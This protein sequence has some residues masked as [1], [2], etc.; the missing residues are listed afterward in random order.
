MEALGKELGVSAGEAAGLVTAV[1]PLFSI[2]ATTIVKDRSGPGVG[3]RHSPGTC[4][5]MSSG[6][7]GR[8][9]ELA[10]SHGRL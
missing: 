4:M 7:G 8:R 2:N 6:W 9:G 10:C 3:A 1:P 5:H